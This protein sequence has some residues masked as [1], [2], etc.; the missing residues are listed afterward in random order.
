MCVCV[1]LSFSKKCSEL[2][3]FQRLEGPGNNSGDSS[4]EPVP[5]S[6]Q[7]QLRKVR[8]KNKLSNSS[9]EVERQCS[10][11]SSL[12]LK[13]YITYWLAYYIHLRI[14]KGQGHMTA[15]MSCFTRVEESCLDIILEHVGDSR[16]YNKWIYK[17]ISK[18][19][20][21]IAI[22]TARQKFLFTTFTVHV[23]TR[24]PHRG[25]KRWQANGGV[26][27][28]GAT[29]CVQ[30]CSMQSSGQECIRVL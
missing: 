30:H 17:D 22:K 21:S 9:C 27:L 28:Y 14:C 11:S 26:C 1:L 18:L 5:R 20:S 10:T 29:E 19:S 23:L 3:V 25:P 7:E 4:T 24:H 13:E 2:E 12:D 16:I 8:K 6:R 15:A